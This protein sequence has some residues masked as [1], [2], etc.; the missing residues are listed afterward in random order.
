MEL[1]VKAIVSLQPP[2]QLRRLGPSSVVVEEVRIGC[3]VL[4]D[5]ARGLQP[6]W[7]RRVYV[8]KAADDGFVIWR[9]IDAADDRYRAALKRIVQVVT[10][11]I[12]AGRVLNGDH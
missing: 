11:V 7:P 2:H 10:D 6:F 3:I 5:G 4:H 1:A 8:G 12:S 9:A